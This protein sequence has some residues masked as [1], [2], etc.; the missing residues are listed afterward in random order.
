MADLNIIKPAQVQTMINKFCCT[1]G[2]LPTSYKASLSYEEQILEIGHYLETVVYPA[3]NN[4]AEALTELQGLFIALQDYVNNYFNNLDVQDE[5]DNKL[6]EMKENGELA[7]II[8]QFIN[9]EVKF[10][11]PKFWANARS[12]DTTLIKYK[13]IVILVDC[14]SPEQW[15]NVKEMID[16]NNVDHIDYFIITHY[17]ADHVGNFE[18]LVNSGYIDTTTKIYLPAPVQWYGNEPTYY[19]NYCQT[20]NL[21]YTLP[22]ENTKVQVDDLLS[23]T[24][25]NT[26]TTAMNQYYNN[27]Q[28]DNI[29]INNSSIV[30]LFE[31]G[32]QKAL[33]VGDCEQ[34]ALKRIRG[35]EFM[36]S[37]VNLYKIGHHGIDEYTDD[38]FIRSISPDFAVQSSGINDA[39]KNE[40]GI[41]ADAAILE[42]LGTAIYPCH[43][44]LDY[45]RINMNQN[46]TYVESGLAGSCSESYAPKT[47]YVDINAQGTYIPDGTQQKPYREIT[48]AIGDIGEQPTMDVRIVVAAGYYGQ[49]ID[50]GSEEGYTYPKNAISQ[51]KPHN[52]TLI[53]AGIGQTILTGL[54]LIN[55]NMRVQDCTIDTDKRYEAIYCLNSSLDMENCNITSYTNTQNTKNG[56]YL[57]KSIVSFDHC[58]FDYCN[59]ALNVLDGSIVTTRSVNYG[60]NVI[61]PIFNRGH[62]REWNTNTDTDNTEILPRKD[63]N[64]IYN[65]GTY[66]SP[67]LIYSGEPEFSSSQINL[68]FDIRK[69]N[70]VKID[71]LDNGG[72]LKSTGILDL[73]HNSRHWIS[74]D[75]TKRIDNDC[76][77]K[78]TSVQFRDGIAMYYQTSI[79]QKIQNVTTTPTITYNTNRDLSV[80]RI[81]GYMFEEYDLQNNT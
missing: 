37:R 80:I 70:A 12:G 61:T 56:T 13:N 6:E 32:T 66:Y 47:M 40:F 8:A 23:F 78:N 16:S 77:I 7:D 50:Y 46:E 59:I 53:G 81:T 76:Y 1:I 29:K 33:L 71:Y 75:L 30:T 2:M 28:G 55:A 58:G 45:I 60:T 17:H 19:T 74:L 36:K 43:K 21:D 73:K 20:N 68:T 34:M 42:E 11:F 67:I 54:R 72:Q 79:N 62:I 22:T 18:N 69:L 57:R 4:N 25:T 49:S 10:I 27:N 39:G 26:D 14:Y 24:F 48:E 35:L 65:F 15:T 44:Q 3:I 41:S 63:Y 38:I 31:Y 52:I 5:I 64:K 9:E 51:Q